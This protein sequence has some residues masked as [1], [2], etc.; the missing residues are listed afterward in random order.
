MASSEDMLYSEKYTDEKFEYRHVIMQKEDG[1]KVPRN[2][3]MTET[4]WRNLGVRQ[5]PGW[6]NYLFHDP[7]P[8]ILCF[9]RSLPPKEEPAA[10]AANNNAQ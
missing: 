4:E 1:G 8:H 10:P 3:R 2:H 6:E 5:S 7:E 9:R